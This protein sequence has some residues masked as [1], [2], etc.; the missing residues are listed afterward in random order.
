METKQLFCY[1]VHKAV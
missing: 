1:Y